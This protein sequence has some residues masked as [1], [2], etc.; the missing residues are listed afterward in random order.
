MLQIIVQLM[1]VMPTEV[2]FAYRSIAPQQGRV[3][4]RYEMN[5]I[6]RMCEEMQRVLVRPYADRR[7]GRG[8]GNV[9]G[10]AIHA[11]HQRA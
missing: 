3:I 6:F 7:S 4:S 2:L 9:Q 8:T 10:T 1:T 11:D 5:H